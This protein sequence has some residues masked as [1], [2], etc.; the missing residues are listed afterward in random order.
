[1]VISL[2]FFVIFDDIY[3]TVMKPPLLKSKFFKLR[4]HK[5]FRFNPLYYDADKERLEERKARIIKELEQE[6]K[7]M[8]REAISMRISFAHKHA[9]RTA[10]KDENRSTI[11]FIVILLVLLYLFYKV[12]INLD[13]ILMVL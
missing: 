2:F 9:Q 7:D 3:H 4:K 12:F 1:M 10:A 11:R 13:G 6:N 8:S 5:Q